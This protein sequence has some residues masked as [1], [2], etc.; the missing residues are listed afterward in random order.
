MSFA[1]RFTAGFLTPIAAIRLL[2]KRR[3]ILLLALLPLLASIALYSFGFTHF[4]SALDAWIANLTTSSWFAEHPWAASALDTVGQI[5]FVVVAILSFNWITTLVAVPIN[6]WLAERTERHTE[7]PI[8]LNEP[9]RLTFLV[10]TTAIDLAKT[11]LAGVLTFLAFA[12]SWIPV[13]NIAAFVASQL[14]ITFQY[15]SYPQTRRRMGFR[16]SAR[17]VLGAFPEC[18]GFGLVHFALFLIPGVSALVLPLAVIG[19]TILFA[20]VEATKL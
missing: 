3:A 12:V 4:Q 7:P 16:T 17:W 15:I 10:R 9:F 11:A 8:A 14:L 2:K 18:F 20:R 13:L 19:G 6:D 1:A 5:L